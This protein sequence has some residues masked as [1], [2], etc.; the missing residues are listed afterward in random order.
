MRWPDAGSYWWVAI[1]AGACFVG[2]AIPFSL[3][4]LLYHLVYAGVIR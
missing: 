4:W 3:M 1:Q 2:C